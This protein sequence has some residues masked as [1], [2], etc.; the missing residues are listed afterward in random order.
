MMCSSAHACTACAILPKSQT[1]SNSTVWPLPCYQSHANAVTLQSGHSTPLLPMVQGA[2]WLN[3]LTY[4]ACCVGIPIKQYCTVTRFYSRSWSIANITGNKTVQ[5]RSRSNIAHFWSAGP[6]S[7]ARWVRIKIDLQA[8]M[9]SATTMK[10][11]KVGCGSSIS[12][13][14]QPIVWSFHPARWSTGFLGLDEP[15]TNL[16]LLR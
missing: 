8:V 10:I 13:H 2:F 14:T 4:R 11:H 15:L 7:E 3:S 5:A 16:Q 1:T 12:I 9:V 6:Y